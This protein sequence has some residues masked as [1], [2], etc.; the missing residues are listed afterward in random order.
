[1]T[2]GFGTFTDAL[3]FGLLNDV[4]AS[5]SDQNAYGRPNLFEVQIHPP[6]K[7]SSPAMGG[8]NIREISL[9]AESFQMPGRSVQTQ[10]ASAG[11]I[12]GPQ[13]EYVTEPLFAEEISMTFQATAGLDERKFFE[14]W[15]QLSYNKD[16]FAAGYYKE[17]V[18][19]LD[20]YLLNQNN[21]KT[22]GLRVEECFPK[23]IAALEL[24]AGPSTEITKTLVSWSFRKF[25][26]LDAE[27]KQ[28]LGG[29]LVDTFT[30]T[31]ERNLTKNIPAVVRKLL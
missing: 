29:T 4:L 19:T 17:Y 15:Q 6:V 23:S 12:T 20:I 5:F 18:G 26:P 30:N 31:V 1:M 28:S 2:T 10:I 27:S 24:A 16:T 8:H 21:R 13:R 11:A 25:E 7:P 3:G 9:R 22:F 14:Q